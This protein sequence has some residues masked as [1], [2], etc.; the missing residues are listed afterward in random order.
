MSAE[1]KSGV[2]IFSGEPHR[3][4]EWEFRAM[5]RFHGSEFDDRW[6]LASKIIEGMQ[7]DAFLVAKDFGLDQLT[8]EDSEP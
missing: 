1:T 6:R 7:G 5:A 4:H 8:E 2:F 3:F